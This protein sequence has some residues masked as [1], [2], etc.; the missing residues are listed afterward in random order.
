MLKFTKRVS[1]PIVSLIFSVLTI[2]PMFGQEEIIH[3]KNPSFEGT[4][5]AGV[6]EYKVVVAGWDD[7]GQYNFP[8]ETPPDLQPGSFEVNTPAHEG[9]TYL[10]LVARINETW[11]SVSQL[12]SA[13][14]KEGNCYS[15]DLHLARSKSYKSMSGFGNENVNIESQAGALVLRIYGGLR[16]CEPR[17]LLA[18]SEVVQH[19]DWRNYLFEFEAKSNLYYITLEAFYKTPVLVP[20]RGNIL[21]DDISEITRVACPDEELIV[22]I[23]PPPK[24][25]IKVPVKKEEPVSPPVVT[26]TEQEAVVPVKRKKEKTITQELNQENITAGQTI[27]INKLFFAADTSSINSGSYSALNEVYDFLQ[28]NPSVRIEIG[29]HTNSVPPDEYCDKLSTAR[30]KAVAAYIIRKG[31][32]PSRIEFRGYGKRNPIANNKTKQGRQKNQRVEIKILNT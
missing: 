29:G 32:Q 23:P 11:E 17:Q 28:E 6:A 3:L 2:F 5:R 25:I 26:N 7:C 15:M 31:I 14:M 27:K 21:V 10:G 13:P 4:P 8:Y 12:L 16:P 19:T 1:V 18:E 9:D 30:A 20:Y 24:P 22:A